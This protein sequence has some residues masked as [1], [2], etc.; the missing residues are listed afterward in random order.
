MAQ[1]SPNR[2][3]DRPA[4]KLGPLCSFSGCPSQ[5]LSVCE[6]DPQSFCW[7]GGV[8]PSHGALDFRFL[9]HWPTRVLRR[10]PHLVA[11]AQGKRRSRDSSLECRFLV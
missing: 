11:F 4:N 5:D 6:C 10:Q 8:S 1:R 9:I 2:I 7:R 3:R